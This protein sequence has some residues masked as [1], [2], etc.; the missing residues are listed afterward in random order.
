MWKLWMMLMLIGCLSRGPEVEDPMRLPDPVED[1]PDCQSLTGTADYRLAGP[2]KVSREST[3]DF[4][5]WLPRSTDQDCQFP[6]V[7]FSNGTEAICE[8]YAS[9][10]EHMASWGLLT[11]CS[12]AENT[13]SGRVC[14]AGINETLENYSDIT[15]PLV[16]SAGHGEGGG[17][18]LACIVWAEGLPLWSQNFLFV[19]AA[20]MPAH[21]MNSPGWREAY[22]EIRAPVFMFHGSRDALV[23]ANWVG[24]G[25]DLLTTEAAWWEAVGATHR[26]SNRWSQTTVTPWFRWR[27]LGD[28]KAKNYFMSRLKSRYWRLIKTK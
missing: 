14:L 16:G 10:L 13:G 24:A 4:K 28:L 15:L 27:L 5:F 21:G 26:T 22:A 19:A 6:M 20:I 8:M 11:V 12:E 25:F 23:G 2:F 1:F 9:L 3:G 18:A 7:H 17:G